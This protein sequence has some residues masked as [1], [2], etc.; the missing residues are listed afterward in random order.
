MN[1]KLAFIVALI[2][3]PGALAISWL[4]LPLLVDLEDIDISLQVLQ[5]A[6][7]F[8]SAV[9]IL[10]ASGIGTLLSVKVGL[11]APLFS[12]LVKRARPSAMVSAITPQLLPGVVGGLLGAVI[13]IAFYEF[14]PRELSVANQASSIPLLARIL[15]GGI[16]EE[17]LI[18]WGLMTTFIWVAW[19]ALQRGK[20]Y[21]S[22]ALVWLCII[23]SAL[24]FG[25][26]H[27]PVIVAGIGSVSLS[28]IAYIVFSNSLFGMIAGY[29]FWRY[30]L[31]SA[32]IAH[33]LAHLVAYFII[34]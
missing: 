23:I 34:G 3:M 5:V 8:Q 31:E 9:L 1:W 7:V 10:L 11:D 17:V 6:T 19:R 24:F 20:G 16:T 29:L 18:R 13:V 32:I 21:P 12:A 2:A 26:S 4:A 30:G 15:Y 27:V 28:V 33:I 22:S 25:A 14:S